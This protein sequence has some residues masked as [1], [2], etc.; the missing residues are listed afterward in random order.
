LNTK[1]SDTDEILECRSLLINKLNQ[2][3]NDITDNDNNLNL[4][5]ECISCLANIIDKLNSDSVMNGK[6][7]EALNKT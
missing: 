5:F 6:N 1:L 3:K 4:A 2:L 7:R